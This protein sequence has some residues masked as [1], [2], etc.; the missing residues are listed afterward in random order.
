[1]GL[2]LDTSFHTLLRRVR[3]SCWRGALLVVVCSLCA[4]RNTPW[5]I[6]SPSPKSPELK[7]QTRPICHSRLI[8]VINSKR[9]KNQRQR[10]RFDEGLRPT[11][12]R[13]GKAP[14]KVPREVLLSPAAAV[15]CDAMRCG[16]EAR[17]MH[18]ALLSC[19]TLHAP[20]Y[21]SLSQVS[22]LC[23]L[24]HRIRFSVSCN[25][26]WRVTDRGGAHL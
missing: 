17:R 8:A 11:W 20:T 23:L 19:S 9:N 24:F 7:L 18:L 21:V 5:K 12:Q 26:V 14:N 10:A 13:R 25:T 22:D 6:P 2:K 1:M 4:H 3:T 15:R 16:Y